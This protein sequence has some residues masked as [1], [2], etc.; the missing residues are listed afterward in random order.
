MKAILKLK[1]AWHVVQSSDAVN[2]FASHTNGVDMKDTANGAVMDD[3][4]V[5]D[6]MC[7]VFLRRLGKV[8]FTCVVDRKDDP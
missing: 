2:A 7:Y 5:E 8:L 3:A 4:S 1:L 6:V